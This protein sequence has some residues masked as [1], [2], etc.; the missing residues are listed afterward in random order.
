MEPR[1]QQTPKV[2]IIIP[3]YNVES[4]LPTCLDSLI[5]QTLC[6]C[7]FIF[8]NDGSTDHSR[9]VIERY[10]IKD[11]RI[12]L[13][14][15]PN[16]GVS[17]A[18]NA[19][20]KAAI[21]EYVGFVDADDW[22][23]A[24]MY[25]ILYSAAAEGN[26]DMVFSNFYIELNGTKRE[27]SCPFP[28]GIHLDRDYITN[29]ILPLYLES[30]D[31]N[32]ICN[33]LFRK[34]LLDDYVIRLAKGVALGEDGLFNMEVLYHSHNV[35]Y[36]DYSGY[37]YRERPGSATRNAARTDYFSR[38]IEVYHSSPPVDIERIIDPDRVKI[39]KA[40][41]LIRSVISFIHVYFMPDT[42]LSFWQKYRQVHTI[43][44][45]AAIREA[46]PAYEEHHGGRLGRYDRVILLMMKARI[47]IGLYGLTAYSR[48]RNKPNI[49]RASK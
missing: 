37:H 28:T 9:S 34:K 44:G 49:R 18:R 15:Q 4:Y 10:Q 19:G 36:V 25:R 11:E 35:T 40:I 48:Y 32:S 6:E 8:V 29:E 43:L 26:Y 20:L 46:L 7:E 5:A 16:S 27:I 1:V 38:A 12:K 14:N 3:V 23:E 22:V 24:D 21:G 41:K 31:F 17:E 47:T 39:K 42:D 13:I 30:D 45:H 2:S 33:K